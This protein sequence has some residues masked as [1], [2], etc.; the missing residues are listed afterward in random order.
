MDPHRN[1]NLLSQFNFLY[2][3]PDTNNT[4]KMWVLHRMVGGP[5]ISLVLIWP[6]LQK[7]PECLIKYENGANLKQNTR[8]VASTTGPERKICGQ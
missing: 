5:V 7:W 2:P 3:Q 8:I 6:N 4:M 1:S